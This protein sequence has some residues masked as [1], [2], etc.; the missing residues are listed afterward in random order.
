MVLFVRIT[1][2]SLTA[3]GSPVPSDRSH[4]VFTNKASVM[5]LVFQERNAAPRSI[6][7]SLTRTVKIKPTQTCVFLFFSAVLKAMTQDPWMLRTLP[8]AQ[9]QHS[10]EEWLTWWCKA[11]PLAAHWHTADADSALL[12][13]ERLARVIHTLWCNV[14]Y[15][16]HIVSVSEEN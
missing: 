3:P 16:K 2:S 1:T 15:C 7:V 5:S 8:K 12:L 9:L 4:K 13:A 10:M 6:W 11:G 14:H